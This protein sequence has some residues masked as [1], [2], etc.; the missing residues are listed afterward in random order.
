MSTFLTKKRRRTVSSKSI[1]TKECSLNTEEALINSVNSCIQEVFELTAGDDYN[2]YKKM[3]LCMN[4]T[5]VGKGGK[6]DICS[7]N[8]TKYP[9]DSAACEQKQLKTKWNIDHEDVSEN[10]FAS[11]GFITSTQNDNTNLAKKNIRVIQE[12]K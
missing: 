6:K 9:R 10:I 8:I 1:D 12:G 2:L 7:E 11:G 3:N 4:E 5:D